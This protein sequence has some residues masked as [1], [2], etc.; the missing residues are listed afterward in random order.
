MMTPPPARNP[1]QYCAAT[2]KVW[3]NPQ[4]IKPGYWLVEQCSGP[5]ATTVDMI[6]VKFDTKF[7]REVASVYRPRYGVA[8]FRFDAWPW[9]WKIT[10]PDQGDLVPQM[11]ELVKKHAP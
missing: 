8:T 4:E 5:K 2:A 9:S 7:W 10:A 1:S 11:L 6:I 3:R